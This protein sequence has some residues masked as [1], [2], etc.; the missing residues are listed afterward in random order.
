MKDLFPVSSV[1]GFSTHPRAADLLNQLF[2]LGRLKEIGEE[3][4]G[5]KKKKG[6][7]K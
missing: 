2:T 4:N 5:K 6:E 3:E 7:K 1:R